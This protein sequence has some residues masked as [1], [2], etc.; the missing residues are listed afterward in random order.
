MAR[1]DKNALSE[2]VSYSNNGMILDIVSP[3]GEKRTFAYEFITYCRV[4]GASGQFCAQTAKAYRVSSVTSSYGYQLVPSYAYYEWVYD[5]TDPYSQPDFTIYSTVIGVGARNLA[6][7]AST[8]I[9]SQSFSYVPSGGITNYNV[10]DA[11]GRQTKYRVGSGGL[12][13]G[14]TFPGHTSEDVTY[15]YSGSI[16]TSIARAGAGTT[17][18]SRSD[19]GNIRTVTVTPPTVTPAMSATVYTFDIA[20]QRMTTV[21]VTENGINRTTT[22]AYDSNGRLTRTTMPEGNYVQLTRDSRGN[23]TENRAV[24]KPASGVVDIVTSAGFDT[25]CSIPAKCNQPNWTRDAKSNQ[26]DYTYDFTHGGVLTVTLPADALGVRPQTRYGY[27]SMQAYYYIGA[28]IV[29][30]GQP[31]FRMT[32][33]SNCRTTASCAGRNG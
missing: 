21:M 3:K 8:T 16:V 13:A 32:S 6:L 17:T 9:A 26:T 4:P 30:S 24:G 12:V 10:T 22:Y 15:S 11:E 27:T 33:I 28:S 18:Y 29:A 14:I 20:M 19:A 5:P 2:Y 31:V 23:V 1:F 7:S 25:T